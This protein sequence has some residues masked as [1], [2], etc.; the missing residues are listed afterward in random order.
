MGWDLL[1]PPTFYVLGT[2]YMP[3]SVQIKMTL[4]FTGFTIDKT[5]P[6]SILIS[7]YTLNGSLANSFL[8]AILLF[9]KI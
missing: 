5:H 6:S 1:T 7:F 9:L 8:L 4:V 2:Y 3:L